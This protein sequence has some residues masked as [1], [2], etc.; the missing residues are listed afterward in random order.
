MWAQF[1]WPY[2]S[3]TQLGIDIGEVDAVGIEETLEQE[4]VLERVNARD[5]Q[6]VGHHTTGGRATP[7]AHDHAELVARRINEVLHDEE[8]AGETHRLHHVELKLD[9]LAHIL[10]QRVAVEAA[11]ALVGQLGEIVGL[12]LDAVDLVV[13]AQALYHG[14]GLVLGQRV[15]AV[16]VRGEFLV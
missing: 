8:V 3:I 13:S 1:S 6:A 15:L 7:R 5:A 4:V 2:L 10:G 11:G 9:M 12:K 14:V 16:L